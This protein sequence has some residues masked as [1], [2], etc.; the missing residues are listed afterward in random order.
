MLFHTTSISELEQSKTNLYNKI[1]TIK[2]VGTATI[3]SERL[4]IK[5]KIN[6]YITSQ[7]DSG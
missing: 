5:L 1:L 2:K 4:S 7:W 6:S 3:N